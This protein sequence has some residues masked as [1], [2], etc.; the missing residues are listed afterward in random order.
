[1]EQR[2][3]DA[4]LSVADG[5]SGA[6]PRRSTRSSSMSATWRWIWSAD[7]PLRPQSAWHAA[8]RSHS[9]QPL[10]DAH[11]DRRAATRRP[12]RRSRVRWADRQSQL[13]P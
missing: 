12:Q 8:P 3:P 7:P 6:A 5:G 11:H 13:R 1:M 2:R 4:S 9:L 10:A